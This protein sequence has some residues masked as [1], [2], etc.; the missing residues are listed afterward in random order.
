MRS[1]AGSIVQL[2]GEHVDHPLDE[3][4]GLGDAERAGVRDPARRLVGVDAGDL[5]VRRLQVVGAGED[6][7]EAGRELGRLGGA[8]ERA[9]VGEHLDPYAEDLA[10]LRRRDLA[11]HVVVAGERGAHQV[12]RAVLDPLDRHAGDDRADDRHHVA[13][14]D[15]DLAAEAAADVRRDDP[16]L[17]LRQ[18]GDERVHRAVRVRRLGGRPDGQLAADRVHVGDRAAGLQ[19][20]RVH[21]GVEDVLGDDHLG[22]GEHL[23][24]LRLVAGLPVEDVVAGAAVLVVADDRGVRVER[25]AGV[26]DR[27]QRVVLHLDELD[28]VARR[29]VVLGDDERD[30]LAL[31]RT[32]SVA[33]TACTS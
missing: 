5:A 4:D 14:V 20:R 9:V 30:L 8:V 25:A 31:K 21:P 29:V 24:G 22:V 26:D 13:R 32:L 33:S 2:D 18:A 23:V 6:V 3:V 10:V 28:R 1:S 27:G 19:R 11:A 16:D 15:A 12:L 17:V 7:E